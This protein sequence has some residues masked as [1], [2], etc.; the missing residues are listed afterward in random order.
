MPR[1]ASSIDDNQ[2]EIVEALRDAGASVQILS[3]V[4]QG[5]PDL[6]VGH[7]FKNLLLEVKDG[8]KIPSKRK[9]TTDEKEWHD[10]WRGSVL[11]VESIDQALAAIGVCP[12]R[13]ANGSVDPITA[14]P[15]SK[16][17]RIE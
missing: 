3:G 11:I 14:R 10:A 17:R 7:K 13:N 4:G 8:R 1:Y 5:C 9:L 12:P 6:L 15:T 2:T 16:P